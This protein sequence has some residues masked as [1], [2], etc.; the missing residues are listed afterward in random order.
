MNIKAL[1]LLRFL[2][3]FVFLSELRRKEEDKNSVWG[4]KKLSCLIILDM[5]TVDD[6]LKFTTRSQGREDTVKSHFMSSEWLRAK[7]L[8]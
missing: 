5:T 2:R 8:G 4:N 7:A 6:F 1:F 3:Q